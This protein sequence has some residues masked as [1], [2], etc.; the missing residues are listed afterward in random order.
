MVSG[1]ADGYPLPPDYVKSMK[2]VFAGNEVT[3]TMAAQIFFKATVHL[4]ASRSPRTIDYHMIGG[5]TAGQ[6]QLGIY[7]I[8]GDTARFCFGAPNAVRPTDFTAVAGDGRT[9]STW[10]RANR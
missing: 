5:P 7:T 3:V 9:L 2:R 1:A 6:V 4:D 10:I 8:T